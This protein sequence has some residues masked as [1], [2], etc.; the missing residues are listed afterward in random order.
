[1]KFILA[2]LYVAHAGLLSEFVPPIDVESLPAPPSETTDSPQHDLV[3][4]AGPH[5]GIDRVKAAPSEL[6]GAELLAAAAAPEAERDRAAREQSLSEQQA[7]DGKH[8]HLELMLSYQV[9]SLDPTARLD[10]DTPKDGHCLFWALACG[11][12][13]DGVA[14]SLT[15]TEIR[16]MALSK[17][18]PEQLSIAAA[19]AA[20]SVPQYPVV[21]I[22]WVE[23][24]MSGNAKTFKLNNYY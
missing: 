16:L 6:L 20:C 3:V 5:A 24:P 10:L 13:Y 1:M 12:L 21:I 18:T 14:E 4:L 7:A 23:F 11:G 17:A 15:I 22:T 9:E 8:R 19:N 2:W